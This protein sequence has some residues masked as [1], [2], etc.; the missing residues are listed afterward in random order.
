MSVLI[1][2]ARRRWRSSL[3]LAFLPRVGIR[4]LPFTRLLLCRLHG[5]GVTRR[6]HLRRRPARFWNIGN[7]GGGDLFLG[8]VGQPRRR[9]GPA[10]FLDGAERELFLCPVEIRLVIEFGTKRL[11]EL[12]GVKRSRHGGNTGIPKNIVTPSLFV[13]VQRHARRISRRHHP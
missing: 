1:S 3:I 12:S 11:Q 10:G 4:N 6:P 9:I 2:S 13:D 7:R 5:L 8:L